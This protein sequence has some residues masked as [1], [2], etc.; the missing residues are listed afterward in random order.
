[1]RKMCNVAFFLLL[2]NIYFISLNVSFAIAAGQYFIML[3]ICTYFPSFSSIFFN[4]KLFANT[5]TFSTHTSRRRP[6]GFAFFLGTN[7]I[8]ISFYLITLYF[9]YY[10]TVNHKTTSE[11]YVLFF[12]IIFKIVLLFFFYIFNIY[13]FVKEPRGKKKHRRDNDK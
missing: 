10:F 11:V 7:D 6:C 12:V 13:F 5:N 3:F 2:L 4:S 9:I 1:M 8:R